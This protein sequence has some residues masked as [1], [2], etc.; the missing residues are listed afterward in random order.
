METI[1]V[2][3]KMLENFTLDLERLLN[4]FEK[5]LDTNVAREADERL[6][7]LKSGKVDGLSEEDYQNFIK[8]MGLKNE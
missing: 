8:K 2:E 6:F 3:K 7:D 5:I 1:I 4:D